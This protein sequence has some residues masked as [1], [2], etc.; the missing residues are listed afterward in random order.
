MDASIQTHKPSGTTPSTAF[1]L[2]PSQGCSPRLEVA[3][4]AFVMFRVFGARPRRCFRH[5]G[6][7]TPFR[8]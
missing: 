7:N 4:L 1:G 3:S 6:D 5:E 8:P 2:K